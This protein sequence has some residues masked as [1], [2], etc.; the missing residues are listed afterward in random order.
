MKA[1]TLPFFRLAPIEVGPETVSLAAGKTPPFEGMKPGKP[2]QVFPKGEAR[3]VDGRQVKC[4][5]EDFQLVLGDLATRKNPV[6]LTVEHECDPLWGS[7]A[8]GECASDAFIVQGD[9]FWGLEPHWTEAALAE[10]KSGARRWISPTFYGTY[11]ETDC[12]RPRILRDVSLVSV[13]NLDGMQPVAASAS[14][15]APPVQASERKEQ[16]MKLSADQMK[17]LG[18][19]EGASQ[20]DFDKS[21]QTFAA[22][23]AE[24]EKK[25]AAVPDTK[26]LVRTELAAEREA[27]RTQVRE[28]MAAERA[29]L[30]RAARVTA[31]VAK[32]TAEGKV[33]ADNR[34]A[35]EKLAA[36]DP[37]AFETVLSSL[38]VHA[39]VKPWFKAGASAAAGAGEKVPVSQMNDPETAK[40]LFERAT[41]LAAEKKVSYSEAL[42][43]LVAA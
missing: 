34:E 39:P 4:E 28:E 41:A 3:T 37:D 25:A 14:K 43:S 21:L 12:V 40:L 8:A 22:A 1:Q 30:D 17:L 11:D 35:L 13:P 6:T 36:A 27:L 7:K 20:E 10:I 31:L 33:V 9:G 38:P 2:I 15:P 19:A 16:E 18:L 5:A 23:K 24:A 29:K 26:E 32:A 42:A